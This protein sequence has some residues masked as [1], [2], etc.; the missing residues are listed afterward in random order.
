MLTDVAEFGSR[1][2]EV[3]GHAH[4]DDH[5][6]YFI[7]QFLI[8]LSLR[9]AL[10]RQFQGHVRDVNAGVLSVKP[11]AFEEGQ[12]L[13]VAAA[14]AQHTSWFVHVLAQGLERGVIAVYVRPL[15]G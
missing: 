2:F 4:D 8:E 9:Y 12:R 5:I 3:L 11:L 6:P 10:L 1:G 13:P 7:R 15:T 14:V